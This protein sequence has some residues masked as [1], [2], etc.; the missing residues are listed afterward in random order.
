[1]T[2]LKK[3]RTLFFRNKDVVA[4]KKKL[5]ELKKKYR[6]I[7]GH[8]NNIVD[9]YNENE[10]EDTDEWLSRLPLQSLSDIYEFSSGEK[11]D[12]SLSKINLQSRLRKEHAE[13]VEEFA[14]LESDIYINEI[15]VILSKIECIKLKLD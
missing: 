5:V 6:A 2:K 10:L 11:D 9:L 4:Q 7:I 1:M 8:I 12:Y 14:K 13:K 15:D 3:A